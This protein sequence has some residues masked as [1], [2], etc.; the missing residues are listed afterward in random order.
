MDSAKEA[1]LNR[2]RSSLRKRVWMWI[3]RKRRMSSTEV[4]RGRHSDIYIYICIDDI[5]F[6]R[7]WIINLK[8]EF[9]NKNIQVYMDIK[10]KKTVRSA[11]SRAHLLRCRTVHV[12]NLIDVTHFEI[13]PATS[14]SFRYLRRRLRPSPSVPVGFT[15]L[16]AHRI[17]RRPQYSRSCACIFPHRQLVSKIRPQP[18]YI[19]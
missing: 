1:N 13:I 18:L 9:E 8:I 5:L 12:S 7:G 11:H 4:R 19:K 15:A 3:L 14:P 6:V 16:P 10:N 2:Y 17:R